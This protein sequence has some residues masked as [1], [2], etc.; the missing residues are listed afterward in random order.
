MFTS[1]MDAV[2]ASLKLLN[3]MENQWCATF[4]HML[5]QLVTHVKYLYDYESLQYHNYVD[6][7]VMDA[8]DWLSSAFFIETY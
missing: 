2:I 5:W 4:K 6:L 1:W 7:Y 3:P 8:Y